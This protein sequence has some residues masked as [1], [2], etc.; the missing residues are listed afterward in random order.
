MKKLIIIIFLGCFI[1]KC[2]GQKEFEATSPNYGNVPILIGEKVPDLTF[3]HVLN[4]E[5]KPLSLSSFKGKAVILDFWGTWCGSCISSFPKMD[6]LQKKYS[7]Y[8]Q[9][10][11]VDDSMVDTLENTTAFVQQHEQDGEIFTIPIIWDKGFT[12]I[13]FPHMSF[14]HY[15]WI[16]ADRRVKAITDGTH[17]T[18]ANFERFFAGLEL[19]LKLKER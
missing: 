9:I 12:P 4:G 11:L 14:P 16:G 15:V 19:N 10:L 1:F 3:L 8:L 6:E 7:K 5:K 13:L 17:F 18:E 2:F